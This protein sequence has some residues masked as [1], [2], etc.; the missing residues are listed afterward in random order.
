MSLIFNPRKTGTGSKNH[1]IQDMKRNSRPLSVPR[2]S[3]NIF[4]ICRPYPI[5]IRQHPSSHSRSGLILRPLK[6]VKIPYFPFCGVKSPWSDSYFPGKRDVGGSNIG[7]GS[8]ACG[9]T[10]RKYLSTWVGRNH[11][12]IYICIH[13]VQVVVIVVFYTRKV[14]FTH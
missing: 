12:H 11:M 1:L 13:A 4:S 8:R 14:C 9:W 6:C 10:R 7:T 5:G 3:Y 2:D